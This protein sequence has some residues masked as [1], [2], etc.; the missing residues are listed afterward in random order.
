MLSFLLFAN[1][2]LQKVVERSSFYHY[3]YFGGWSNSQEF[4]YNF[5]PIENKTIS[6]N[7]ILLLLTNKEMDLVDLTISPTNDHQ[8]YFSYAYHELVQ[9]VPRRVSEG[10]YREARNVG[11]KKI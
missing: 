10:E 7:S 3:V 8:F 1:Y 9:E 2:S 11:W 5:T 6:Y 4:K